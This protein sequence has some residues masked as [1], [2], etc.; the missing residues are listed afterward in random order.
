MKEKRDEEVKKGQRKG[1][2]KIQDFYP[3]KQNP[4]F[5]PRNSFWASLVGRSPKPLYCF[6]F[7]VPLS[8]FFPLPFTTFSL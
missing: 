5:K 2:G 7:C 1:T 3:P 8:F 4:H 6:F